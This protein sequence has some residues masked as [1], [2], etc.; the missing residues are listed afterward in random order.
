MTLQIKNPNKK[1]PQ[2]LIF[3]NRS[4]ILYPDKKNDERRTEIFR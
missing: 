2:K 1:S 3:L 4:A